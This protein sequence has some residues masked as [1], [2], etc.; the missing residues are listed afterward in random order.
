[1]VGTVQLHPAWAPNQPRRAEI[2]KLIV[3]RESRGAG[4]GTQLMRTI[5]E[6]AR[7]A[8]F[9]LLTLDTKRG[10]AAERLYRRLGWTE[11]G[12]IPRYALDPDGSTHHDAVIFYKHLD[13]ARGDPGRARGR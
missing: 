4:L 3:H 11:A 12:V 9:E 6:E 7:R 13:A 8:G 1:M 2:V 5:E 10:V